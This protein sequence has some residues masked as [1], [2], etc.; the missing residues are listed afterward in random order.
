MPVYNSEKY[1][2]EAIKSILNQTFKEFEFIIIDD[3][4]TDKSLEIIN[5]YKDPR[6][7]LIKHKTNKG[8]IYSLNEG[9][10]KTNGKYIAR[11]DAD[12]V[13]VKTRLAKQIEFLE[14]NK[15]IS[16][17]GSWIKNFGD[18]NYTWRTIANPKLLRSRMLFESS[19][20]HPSVIF[21]KKDLTNFQYEKEYPYAE[22]FV[23][24]VKAAEKL[25]LSNYPEVLL[26]YRIHPGQTPIK[27]K[28]AQQNSSWKVRKYQLNK[29]GIKP[30]KKYKDLHQKLSNWSR[31]FS[32]LDFFTAAFWLRLILIKNLKKHYYDQKSLNKVISER[33]A[34]ILSLHYKNNPLIL[35]I[36]VIH[37]DLTLL[38][39]YFLITGNLKK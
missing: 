31:N 2:K 22:D 8:I 9:L 35:L 29:L 12:D 6:I 36:A 17:L 37:F 16:I 1:L 14:K 10:K 3:G 13:A 21:R 26:K 18:K 4:S 27:N 5:E 7:V 15:D 19:L 38:S 23:L 32:F 33:W 39:I 28:R 25:Q 24:W 34:G 20:A 30:T 11:M